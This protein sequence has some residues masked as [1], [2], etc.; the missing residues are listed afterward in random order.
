MS[1]Y[2]AFNI[3]VQAEQMRNAQK[4]YFQQISKAKKSK[5]PDDFAAASNI[6][7]ISKQLEQSF[8]DT[9]QEVLNEVNLTDH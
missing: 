1:K 4:L 7:R 5:L 9:V 2:S 3:A 6:L 8:D